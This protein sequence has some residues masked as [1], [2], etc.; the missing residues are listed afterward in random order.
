VSD[1]QHDWLSPD[2]PAPANV[3]SIVT[4]RNGGVSIGS[5]ASLNL[6]RH[7]GDEPGAVAENRRRLCATLPHEPLWLNQIHGTNVI[8]LDARTDTLAINTA[9]A[10]VTSLPDRPCAVMVADC[11]PVLFCDEAGTCV[12]AAHA[13]WRGLAA[14]VLE[15]T[16]VAMRVPPE[17]LLAYLGPAIGPDAFEVGCDVRDTFAAIDSAS[18]TAFTSVVERPEK[19]L[20][21]IFAL[22]RQRLARAG[23]RRIYGGT[24]CTVAAPDRFFSYRR[25]GTTGRMAAVIWLQ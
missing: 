7:V 23:V 21:N 8:R 20:A 19:F 1:P 6:G 2:W 4:T 14:G 16:I 9:D 11:L 12:G 18:Q 22:A 17:R 3:R 5:F 24:D 25:D 10:A 15:A 13:G